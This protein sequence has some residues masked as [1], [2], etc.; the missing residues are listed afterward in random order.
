VILSLT[1]GYLTW[2]VYG[3]LSKPIQTLFEGVAAWL[4]V[5]VLSYMIFWM[6]EKRR[7]I[8]TEIQ[9]RV[10]TVTTYKTI[11]GLTSLAFVVVFREGIESVLFLLPF[12]V[13]EPFATV[14]GSFSG[15]LIALMFAYVI[16]IT[17]MRINIQRFFYFTSILLVLLAGGLADYGVHELIE[18][19]KLSGM[20]LGWIAEYAY[21]LNIPSESIF[22]HKGIIGSIFAVMFGYTVSS[23]WARTIIHL[24]YLLIVLPI[25]LIIYRNN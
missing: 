14:V 25:V 6:A 13:N 3:S 17:G 19:S 11:L 2:L 5:L 12:L 18:F 15:I 24:M 21:V 10:E 16:F 1:I 4:A 8:R 7:V 22:H 23:E 9:K 20:E